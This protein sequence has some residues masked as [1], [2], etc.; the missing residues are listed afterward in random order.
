M[1]IEIIKYHFKADC[2]V[3]MKNK[4]ITNKRWQCIDN[5]YIG[6][7]WNHVRMQENVIWNV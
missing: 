7:Q 5:C 2:Q 3:R 6:L 1:K 4:S